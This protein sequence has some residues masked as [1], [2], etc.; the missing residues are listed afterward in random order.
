MT[1]AGMR[2][3]QALA[4]LAEVFKVTYSVP[5]SYVLALQGVHALST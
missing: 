3:A 5:H 1:D 2:A 4:F